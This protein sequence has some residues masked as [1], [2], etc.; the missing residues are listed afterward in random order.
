VPFDLNSAHGGAGGSFS[1]HSYIF[2]FLEAGRGGYFVYFCVKFVEGMVGEARE[3][4]P[5]GV[6]V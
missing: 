4:V 1:R 3:W 2:M 5:G 6:S